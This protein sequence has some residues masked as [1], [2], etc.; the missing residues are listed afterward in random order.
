MGA[1]AEPADQREQQEAHRDCRPD[2]LL[3]EQHQVFP[4]HHRVELALAVQP[5]AEIERHLGEGERPRRGGEQIQ[6]DLEPLARQRA[7]RLGKGLALDQEKP[8]HRVGQIGLDDQPAEPVGD[9]A[10]HHPRALPLADPAMPDMP[11]GDDDVEAF[12]L[13]L[14]QHCRESGPVHGRLGDTGLGELRLVV[15]EE[16]GIQV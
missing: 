6:Q 16:L 10:D 15:D 8:A 3:K 7:H 12:G 11:A 2:E 9:V 4:G 5:L 13:D 1:D 14:V